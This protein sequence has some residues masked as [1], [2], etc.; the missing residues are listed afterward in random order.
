MQLHSEMEGIMRRIQQCAACLALLIALGTQAPP[1]KA[2][3][4]SVGIRIGDRYRGPRIAY[5][6]QPDVVVIPGTNVYY[7]QASDYDL[8][9]YGNRWY[10]YYDGGWYTARRYN[11]PYAFISYQSVPRQ[12]RYVPADYRSWRSPRGYA[13]GRYRNG[14]WYRSNN[15]QENQTWERDA[16]GRRHDNN[17]NNNDYR[18][19][20]GYHRN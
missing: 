14:R 6:R 15:W 4:V 9:R 2:A 3:D 8:Y 7:M 17:D 18:G 12:I 1:A 16:R 19:Q 10:T 5:V 13:Y 20:N 11:G